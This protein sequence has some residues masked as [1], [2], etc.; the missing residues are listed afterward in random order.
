MP[1]LMTKEILGSSFL[2]V[3]GDETWKAKRR[4]CAHAFYK[5]KLEAMLDISKGQAQNR[6]QAWLHKM[7]S[8]GTNNTKTVVDI[9]EQF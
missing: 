9:S 2:M 8:Q 4:A 3:K 5:D 1:F 6:L 7:A